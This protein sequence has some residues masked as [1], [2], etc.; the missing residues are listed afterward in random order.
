MRN[1]VVEG[2]SS[3]RRRGLHTS[4]ACCVPS[5]HSLQRLCHGVL[6]GVRGPAL[7][8]LSADP[9]SIHPWDLR[10][11]LCPCARHGEHMAQQPCRE[12]HRGTASPIPHL[13][14]QAEDERPGDAVLTWLSLQ[15]LCFQLSDPLPVSILNNGFRGTLMT[16]AGMWGRH[17]WLV[18]GCKET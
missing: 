13:G 4:Q 3:R 17:M 18:R 12:S 9:P 11:L 1:E 6:S 15:E 16:R 2:C 8:Q 10:A 7:L 5:T 14:E